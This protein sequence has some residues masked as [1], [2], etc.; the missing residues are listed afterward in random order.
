M[1]SIKQFVAGSLLATVAVAA[2]AA[3]VQ[4]TVASGGNGHWY[5]RLTLVTAGGYTWNEAF[6]HAPTQSWQGQSGYMATVTSQAEQDFLIATF[7][8]AAAWLGGNDRETEGT[9][10]WVNGPEAG[11]AFYVAGAGVQPGYSR[12]GGGEP[13][14]CCRGEDDVVYGYFGDPGA[15][16]N[17]HG[18]PSFTDQR[19]SYFIEYNDQR[20]QVP[21]PGSLVLLAGGLLAAGLRRR[22]AA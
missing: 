18:S 15:V 3:P 17:D 11:Q 20:L 16:W 13:N 6:A 14:N 9:F 5:E 7:G 21:E 19:W 22:R 1:I 4:W 10:K 8:I 12:F 2:S